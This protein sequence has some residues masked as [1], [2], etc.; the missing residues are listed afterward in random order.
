M[1]SVHWMNAVDSVLCASG[2]CAPLTLDQTLDKVKLWQLENIQLRWCPANYKMV[3]SSYLWIVWQSPFLLSHLTL[4]SP[5]LLLNC[6]THK[7]GRLRRWF[8]KVFY[9]SKCKKKKWRRSW[10]CRFPSHF[11]MPDSRSHCFETFLTFLFRH[12]IKDQS[13]QLFCSQHAP[14][15]VFSCIWNSELD[16]VRVLILMEK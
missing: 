14:I 11:P 6:Q 7:K 4:S 13:A 10:S 2:Q 12:I 16:P 8:F 15:C 5:P 3:C 1:E 9:R